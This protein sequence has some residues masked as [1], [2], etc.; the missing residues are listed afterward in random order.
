VSG[1]GAVAVG[2]VVAVGVAV[3]VG[4]VMVGVGLL[5]RGAHAGFLLEFLDSARV[6]GSR[7]GAGGLEAGVRQCLD[8]GLQVLPGTL[9]GSG[10]GDDN[11]LVPDT[12]DGA[13]HHGEGGDCK[14]GSKHAVDKPR[15]LLVQQDGDGF[16]GV[17]GDGKA[18]AACRD[19]QVDGL[20]GVCPECNL[21]LDLGGD[22]AH[23][24]GLDHLPPAPAIFLK[25]I[26][27]RGF[28]GIGRGVVGGCRR[29]DQN[30]RS[31]RG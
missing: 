22:V 14:R 3:G 19:D 16:G 2:V 11:G 29:D 7:V 8:D 13:R 24:L 17:V 5:G 1:E 26:S 18:C 21:A 4:V 9:G 6:E 20:G 27:E 12:G 23:D 10:Q 15:C 28:G 30:C 31:Q 25:N